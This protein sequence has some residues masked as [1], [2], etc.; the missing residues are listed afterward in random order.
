MALDALL[1]NEARAEIER[2]R[3]QGRE[4]A[5]AIVRDA[6]ERAQSLLESRQRALE[7]QMQA[8]LVRARSA[9]DLEV[10]AARLNA[11]EG[12]MRRAFEIAEGQLR[13]VTQAPE[14]REILS[15][16]IQEVRAAMPDVEAI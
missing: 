14:Y 4:R 2:V 1:E 12:G 7:T 15:R 11:N 13:G 5:Q 3:A 8:G 10:S 16:L 9:A 6:Q